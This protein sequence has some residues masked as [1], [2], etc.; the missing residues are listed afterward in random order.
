M[1]SHCGHHHGAI[2]SCLPLPP[3]FRAPRSKAQED[4]EDSSEPTPTPKQV[5]GVVRG[6]W[7]GKLAAV[8]TF[9]N[10]KTRG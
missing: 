8:I 1:H 6:R 3:S 5:R 10:I 7:G 4:E 2:L 9:Y